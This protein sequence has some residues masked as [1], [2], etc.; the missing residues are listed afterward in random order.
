[1]EMEIYRKTNI[2]AVFHPVAPDWLPTEAKQGWAWSVP[3]RET[4]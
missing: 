2:T 1:M 3:G 4:C